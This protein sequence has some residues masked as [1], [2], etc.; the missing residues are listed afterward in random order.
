MR[1]FLLIAALAAAPAVA[2]G[3]PLSDAI[4]CAGGATA[5]HDFAEA[6]RD[7]S[8]L[9]DTA[10]PVLADKRDALVA[11]AVAQGEDRDVAA[12][13]TQSGIDASAEDLLFAM[14]ARALALSETDSPEGATRQVIG[15]ALTRLGG[16]PV[17]DSG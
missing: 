7:F 10:L 6:M 5:L 11:Y 2:Q 1:R 9:P 8:G 15:A 13:T 16:C 3:D 12:E 4:V 14:N 17:D